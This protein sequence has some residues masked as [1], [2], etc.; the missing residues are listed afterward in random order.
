MNNNLI[1]KNR[2]FYLMMIMLISLMAFSLAGCKEK[3]MCISHADRK[4]QSVEFEKCLDRVS[5]AR[6][7]THYTTHDDE[8]FEHVIKECRISARQIASIRVCGTRDERNDE[9]KK[10]Q[11]NFDDQ[12]GET[13]EIQ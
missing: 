12:K 2:W 4:I 11:W 7:G 5:Y 6:A 9:I 10:M 1:F 3:T 8:D 13:S